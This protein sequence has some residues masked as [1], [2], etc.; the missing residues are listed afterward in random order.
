MFVDHRNIKWLYGFR[1]GEIVA[2]ATMNNDP[3]ASLFSA[4]Q[5]AGTTLMKSDV[6]WVNLIESE[7]YLIN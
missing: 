4:L 5:Q 1:K 7:Y 3:I 2:V 6:L